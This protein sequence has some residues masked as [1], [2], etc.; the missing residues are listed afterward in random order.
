MASCFHQGCTDT[1]S[2]PCFCPCAA[3]LCPCAVHMCP[4]LSPCVP[5]LP[6]LCSSWCSCAPAGCASTCS[7]QGYTDPASAPCVCLCA[8][9]VVQ[10]LVLLCPS[11]LRFHKAS[12]APVVSLT[13]H[14]LAPSLRPLRPAHPKDP[15]KSTTANTSTNSTT[16]GTSNT[17]ANSTINSTTS[18]S[19]SSGDGP[20]N[21]TSTSGRNATDATGAAGATGGDAGGAPVV[22]HQ[23][24]KDPRGNPCL[25]YGGSVSGAGMGVA[26]LAGGTPAASGTPVDSQD[27]AQAA[28]VRV[29]VVSWEDRL[30]ALQVRRGACD[31][32][33]KGQK[34]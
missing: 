15:S 33:Y 34:L 10:L 8:A 23:H 32:W 21:A 19:S 1:A 9:P 3:P 2:A 12:G 31:V 7:H 28:V 6:L 17:S 24:V 4:W 30:A 11:S 29:R 26:L 25:Y 20:A 18:A 5:A 16:E 13:L 27:G 14:D 22:H